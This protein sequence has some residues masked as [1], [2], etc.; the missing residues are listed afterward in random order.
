MMYKFA[1]AVLALALAGALVIGC[2]KDESGQSQADQAA[3][4]LALL[5]DVDMDAVA[6]TVNGTDITNGQVAN[7]EGRLLQQLGGRV[8]P[9]QLTR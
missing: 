1:V 2:S 7:E 6:V 8:D 3:G 5:G 9:Q 4:E